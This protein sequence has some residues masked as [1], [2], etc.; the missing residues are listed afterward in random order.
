MTFTGKASDWPKQLKT[1]LLNAIN[2]AIIKIAAIARIY[3]S[4]HQNI[5][6]HDLKPVQLVSTASG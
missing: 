4:K 6:E 2:V 3:C 5:S 1:D